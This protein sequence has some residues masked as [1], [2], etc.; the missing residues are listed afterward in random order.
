MIFTNY[1]CEKCGAVPVGKVGEPHPK[2]CPKCA[3]EREHEKNLKIAKELWEEFGDVIV[4]DNECI[5]SPWRTFDAG[6]SRYDIWHWFES[7]F[8]VSVAKDLM[9]VS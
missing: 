5:E 1:Y 7:F 6:V 8:G 4:D 9:E 2:Y 3:A